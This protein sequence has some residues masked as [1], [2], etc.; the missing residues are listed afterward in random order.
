M[1]DRGI[2]TRIAVAVAL[3][4]ALS[5]VF[6]GAASASG[7][8][9]GEARAHAGFRA[10]SDLNYTPSEQAQTVGMQAFSDLNYTPS[11]QAQTVGMQAFSDPNAF[12]PVPKVVTVYTSSPSHIGTQSWAANWRTVALSI[13][14]GLLALS[15]GLV[16]IRSRRAQH[17][18]A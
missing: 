17:T 13:L 10:F 16:A 18:L 3:S 8:G 14:A 2:G 12:G 6:A 9:Y 1:G 15:L 7:T 11:E 5:T 4:F